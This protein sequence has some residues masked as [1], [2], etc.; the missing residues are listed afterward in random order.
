ME[1]LLFIIRFSVFLRG[2]R[3]PHADTL[4]IFLAMYIFIVS[5]SFVPFTFFANFS[6][7]IIFLITF[8]VRML[9][10]GN[11]VFINIYQY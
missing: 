4:G 5:L 10:V 8:F 7:H 6:I 3:Q 1:V 9:S 2:T 11:R